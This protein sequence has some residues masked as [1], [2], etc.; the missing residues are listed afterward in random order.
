MLE[1]TLRRS[2]RGSATVE[3]ALILPAL[4]LILAGM[5]TIG[6]YLTARYHLTAAAN[7]AARACSYPDDQIPNRLVCVQQE[8]ENRTPEFVRRRCALLQP[9]P[10]IQQLPDVPVQVL[11]VTITCGYQPAILGG[12][13]NTVGIPFPVLITQGT[14]PLNL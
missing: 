9:Q 13:M 6:N 3:F 7:Q 1:E 12:F 5:F 10:T 8:V 14:M 11:H 4:L 2:S